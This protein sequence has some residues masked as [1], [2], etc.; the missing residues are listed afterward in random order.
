MKYA[1][2][3]LLLAS[4]LTA[5]TQRHD[6]IPNDF[7]DS[8]ALHDSVHLSD[9]LLQTGLQQA[10]E[11]DDSLHVSMI[12]FFQGKK[13][14]QGYFLLR[15]QERYE[16]AQRYLPAQAPPRLRMELDI[17][18]ADLCRFNHFEKRENQ[19][20]DNAQQL[21]TAQ[22]DSLMLIRICFLR[23]QREKSKKDFARALDELHTAYRYACAITPERRAELQAEMAV[24][25]LYMQQPD[26]A[27]LHLDRAIAT[28]AGRQEYY[29]ALRQGVRYHIARNDSALPYFRRIA[30][31]F[32][33]ARKTDAYRYMNIYVDVSSRL[34]YMFSG[35]KKLVVVNQTAGIF[36]ELKP[37]ENSIVVELVQ[38]EWEHDGRI[39][40]SHN[41]K[42]QYL[43]YNKNERWY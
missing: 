11:A 22:Q 10:I 17:A 33:L 7:W 26:S 40:K 31:M 29:H 25:H 30:E 15:A 23:C 37:G 27:L 32:P 19:L 9:S 5:C 36:P 43:G 12:C 35:S 16:K 1:L 38:E 24:V 28:Q 4:W 13:L 14:H 39:Y 20:L 21:A 18:Q 42:L 41:Q 2:L 6:D 34:A 3:F 8:I